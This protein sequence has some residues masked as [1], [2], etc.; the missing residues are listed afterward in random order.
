MK[1]STF[2]FVRFVKFMVKITTMTSPKPNVPKA[3]PY[4]RG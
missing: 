3:R 1:D 4:V 2:K